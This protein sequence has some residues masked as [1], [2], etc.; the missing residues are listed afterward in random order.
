MPQETVVEEVKALMIERHPQWAGQD[1]IEKGVG[2]F[3]CHRLT[4][5]VPS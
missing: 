2:C 4:T 1:W 5:P 3:C